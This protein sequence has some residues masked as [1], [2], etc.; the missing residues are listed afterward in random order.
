[1]TDIRKLP[2]VLTVMGL[3][4]VA[5][6]ADIKLNDNLTTTGFID[7]SLN[8]Y[9]PDK[10]PAALNASLDQYEL[11]F[12][13]KYG[14]VS[15][16]ADVNGMP[17]SDPVPGKPP[18]SNASVWVEQAYVTG[19]MGALAVSAGRFLSSSGWEA[20]EPTGMYQYSYS[21]N[22]FYG[23]YQNGLN[24]SYSQPK[25]A[26][27]GA[28]VSDLWNPQ[29]YDLK[30]TPGFEGQVALMPVEGVTAKVTYLYQMFD[31]DASG[32]DDQQLLNAWASYAKGPLTVAGEY[33]LMLD[34][35]TFSPAND[36]AKSK[37]DDTGNGWL[38]MANYKFTPVVAATVRYSG[39]KFSK[40]DQ[41]TEVTLA[42][43]FQASPNW[44][45]V[46][47]GKYEIDLK[48]VDYALESTFSF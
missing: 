44:L 39:N 7:M 46:A 45:L 30:K 33:S 26:L 19:T 42:P 35:N 17:S 25:F 38:V 5:A 22:L 29:E 34:W 20:A 1:M 47:E 13:Y 9:T 41:D 3:G 28:V 21:K 10:G 40:L 36:S 23:Y 12:L 15:A 24:L 27:Y 11:D 31:K 37:L 8:G 16:R 4:A 32:K 18:G 2:L 14:N 48:K 43:S 6:N